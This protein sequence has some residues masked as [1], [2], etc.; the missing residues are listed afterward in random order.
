MV[1]K[2]SL[3]FPPKNRRLARVISIKSPTRFRNSIRTL[4]KNGITLTERRALL[5][6][7]TRA[8]VQLRRPNLSL[9]ERKQFRVISRMTVPLVTRRR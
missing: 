5:L 6:A 1:F 7:R 3:F 4:R 9:K 2:K 8:K